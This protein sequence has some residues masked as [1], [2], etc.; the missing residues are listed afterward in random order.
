[1]LVNNNLLTGMLYCTDMWLLGQW[2]LIQVIQ[3]FGFL[4]HLKH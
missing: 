2:L 3:K 1:M 4:N